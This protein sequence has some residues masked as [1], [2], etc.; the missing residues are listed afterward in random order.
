[1]ASGRRWDVRRALV[2]FGVAMMAFGL[3]GP[4]PAVGQVDGTALSPQKFAEVASV[5]H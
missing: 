4:E 2:I 1:M 3:G 5:W